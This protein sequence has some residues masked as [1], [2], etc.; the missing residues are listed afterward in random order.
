MAYIWSYKIKHCF[1]LM[2]KIIV[3]RS[4]RGKKSPPESPK[5]ED[6]PPREPSA[7]SENYTPTVEAS[8]VEAPDLP[9][10]LPPSSCT[11]NS[12]GQTGRS[13]RPASRSSVKRSADAHEMETHEEE[14]KSIAI[15]PKK[16][17]GNEIEREPSPPSKRH[18]IDLS[19]WINQRVLA[20]RD[21]LYQP[22]QISDI[23]Q[24]RHIGV[25][26]DSDK[27]TVYFND[28]MDQR[29][30]FDII[31]DHSPMA[32][33]TNVGSKVCVRIIPEENYYYEGV[34]I[35]KK[36][37]PV[38]YYVQIQGHHEDKF[39]DP[40]WVSRAVLRLIQPP[41]YEDLQNLPEQQEA[42]TPLSTMAFPLQLQMPHHQIA[43]HHY[44][45]Q[46]EISPPLQGRME[47]SPSL[48]QS[49]SIERGESS[50]DEMKS[51]D[52]DFDSGLSTPRSGSATPGSG[53][54]SQGGSGGNRPP[55]KK[56][57][58]SRSR[59]VQSC[60]SSR[61]STPRS[62]SSTQKYKKGDV[63]STPNGIRKKFNGKQWRRL[64]SKEG[65]TKESQRRG[66]CSRHLSMKGQKNMRGNM[67]QFRKGEHMEWSE[68]STRE[69][70]VTDF[71]PEHPQRFDET[72]AANMLV[73]LGN[74][75]STTPAFSPT[76]SNHPISPHP[77]Q[78]PSTM[79]PRGNPLSFAPIS[80]HPQTQA[81]M[82]S[83]TRSWS[84]GTSKSGSSSS[85]HVSPITPRFPPTSHAHM[86]NAPEME[87][88]YQKIANASNFKI[89]PVKAGQEGS[90][91]QVTFDTST[92]I[93]HAPQRLPAGS[94]SVMPLTQDMQARKMTHSLSM[95]ALP[96]PNPDRHKE[97]NNR[98]ATPSSRI[99][100]SSMST[101]KSLIN[102]AP[103]KPQTAIVAP[104]SSPDHIPSVIQQQIQHQIPAQS[105]LPIMPVANGGKNEQPAPV[106]SAPGMLSY[107]F[108]L[109]NLTC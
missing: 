60:E 25:L 105:L 7:H 108:S 78:S 70:S 14:K 72:E 55:P 11:P 100:Q 99:S 106:N 89:D 97:L 67:Q 13:S 50:E 64:C 62:P 38:S 35:D 12:E 76:P 104:V 45:P 6:P 63:V 48:P 84:S 59:S 51:E 107:F 15:P 75:R 68:S 71:D 10:P 26:F 56:R 93:L 86:Y 42:P 94:V 18:S 54:R 81:F 43:H 88:L 41:W 47:R 28:V 21:G 69:S 34:I 5:Q 58:F 36:S 16:R 101:L 30:Q 20:K 95:S 65:C 82:T 87:Q 83:P 98:T 22:G 44:A 61:S 52:I 3:G 2:Y 77:V 29:A 4:G 39:R 73:S 109:S 23:R 92:G 80:P 24:N 40:Q 57:E 32:M 19:E 85:E 79:G 90:K 96:S 27:N 74:S 9:P 46:L 8:R 66:Y 91:A 102:S 103:I 33:M 1:L 49:T 37:Q 53:C 31:S 17:K